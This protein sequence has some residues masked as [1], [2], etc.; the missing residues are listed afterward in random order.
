MILGCFKMRYKCR[1]CGFQTNIKSQIH[2]HHI[3]PRQAGG[4]NSKW[5]LVMLCARC[6][7]LI[8]SPYATKGIHS[9][10]HKQSIEIITWRDSTS[11]KLLECIFPDG[12]LKY[13]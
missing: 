13:I 5:N 9:K 12:Q 10:K 1:L 8:W 7:P 3:K 11:G 4:T 2:I 6:H